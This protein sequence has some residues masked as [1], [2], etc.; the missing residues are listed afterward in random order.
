MAAGLILIYE[1]DHNYYLVN[2]H[3]SNEYYEFGYI[4]KIHLGKY[5]FFTK[6]ISIFLQINCNQKLF[7][8]SFFCM[9]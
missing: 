6:I 4:P 7:I 1:S 3:E 9:K 5:F 8:F 2:S